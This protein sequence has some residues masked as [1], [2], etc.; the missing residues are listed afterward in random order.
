MMRTPE[1]AGIAAGAGRSSAVPGGGC[2]ARWSPKNV[3]CQSQQQR[4]CDEADDQSKRLPRKGTPLF[5]PLDRRQTCPG[6]CRLEI[7][8]WRLGAIWNC[9]CGNGASIVDHAGWFT[10]QQRLPNSINQP[11]RCDWRSQLPPD[12]DKLV[13][14]TPNGSD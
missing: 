10:R 14:P 2:D 1:P 7:D 9:D 8:A 4:T 13:R 12:C 6:G 3:S 5:R 11:A